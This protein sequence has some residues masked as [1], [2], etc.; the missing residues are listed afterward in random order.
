MINRLEHRKKTDKQVLEEII[1]IQS[2]LNKILQSDNDITESLRKVGLDEIEKVLSEIVAMVK[3][4]VATRTVGMLRSY[5]ERIDSAMA[6]II[7]H[8]NNDPIYSMTNFKYINDIQEWHTSLKDTVFSVLLSTLLSRRL[9]NNSNN[10][11]LEI[12]RE[13]ISEFRNHFSRNILHFFSDPK[14]IGPEGNLLLMDFDNAIINFARKI[15]NPG[16]K[17]NIVIDFDNEFRKFTEDVRDIFFIQNS[18]NKGY[19]L[20]GGFKKET[21]NLFLQDLPN[22]ANAIIGMD[23]RKKPH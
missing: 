8:V 14:T 23:K 22:L 6:T 10:N 11:F 21:V 20:R 4:G 2:E 5:E 16:K 7:R 1:K 12:N 3:V 18:E 13:L 15:D 19:Q 17:K 9:E